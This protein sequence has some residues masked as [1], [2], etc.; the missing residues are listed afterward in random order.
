MDSWHLKTNSHLSTSVPEKNKAPSR[1]GGTFSNRL[2]PS[3][4][5]PVQMP[6]GNKVTIRKKVTQDAN[7]Q[8]VAV[9]HHLRQ[10]SNSPIYAR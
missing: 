4:A 8:R 7:L 6:M 9:L 1:V 3:Q 2:I 10:A 5:A